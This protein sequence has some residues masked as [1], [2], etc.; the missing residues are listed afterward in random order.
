MERALILW[1]IVT[2]HDPAQGT[3]E[4]EFADCSQIAMYTLLTLDGQL[5]DPQE[6]MRILPTRT[7][8]VSVRDLGDA[9]SKLGVRLSPVKLTRRDCT[10]CGTFIAFVEREGKPYGHYLV[11]RPI[12][13]TYLQIID[14]PHVY[15]VP[16]ERMFPNSETAVV[17]LIR[18]RSGPRQ[19]AGWVAGRLRHSG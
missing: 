6:L 2:V 10:Q 4:G 15:I 12:G 11:V 16:V 19:V 1:L 7:A 13:E 5:C 9:G 17:A 8:G 3:A 18:A 14:T